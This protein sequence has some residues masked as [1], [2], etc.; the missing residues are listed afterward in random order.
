MLMWLLP[1]GAIY[2]W[3]SLK[4]EKQIA[5]YMKRYRKWQDQRNPKPPPEPKV[6][7]W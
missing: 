2:L 6:K 5:R 1:F 7:R 4:Y 3:L